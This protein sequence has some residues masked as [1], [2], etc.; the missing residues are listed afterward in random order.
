[1]LWEMTYKEEDYDEDNDTEEEEDEDDEEEEDV[2][3]R[4][5]KD[6]EDPTGGRIA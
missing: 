4:V 2:R 6:L 1:M 3:E 5:K